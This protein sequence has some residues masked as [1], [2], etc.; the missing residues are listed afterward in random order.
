[1]VKGALLLTDVRER[2]WG[3]GD[4]KRSLL[5]EFGL[6]KKARSQK[7]QTAQDKL[8]DKCFRVSSP[9]MRGARR[10]RRRHIA[11]SHFLFLDQFVFLPPKLT[12]LLPVKCQAFRL[13]CCQGNNDR[14]AAKLHRH[15]GKWEANLLSGSKPDNS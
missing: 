9:A 13:H 15:T 4:M 8:P 7:H 12:S 3:G 14:M 2:V 11:Q 6:N 1:M 10:Q 5:G